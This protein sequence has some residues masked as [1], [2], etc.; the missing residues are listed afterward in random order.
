MSP[1]PPSAA[2]CSSTTN[3]IPTTDIDDQKHMT[4]TLLRRL[5]IEQDGYETP[6]LNDKLYL[7]FQGFPSLCP[8]ALAPYVGLKALWL[9]SNGLSEI[10]GLNHLG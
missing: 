9:D 6:E 1:S 10:E 3:S 2:S 4:P 5:C 7:H 8:Q